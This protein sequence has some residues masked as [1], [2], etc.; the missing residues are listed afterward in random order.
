[1]VGYPT[2]GGIWGY[3]LCERCNNFTGREY[4]SEHEKWVRAAGALL[5]ALPE[6]L[7]ATGVQTEG[8]EEALHYLDEQLG[9]ATFDV[10]LREVDGARFVRQVLS[11]MCSIAGPWM[12]TTQH[13]EVRRIVLE[14]ERLALP[15]PLALVMNLQVGSVRVIGPTLEIQNDG[16]WR[17]VCEVAYP[18]FALLMVLARSP[19]DTPVAGTSLAQL[20]EIPFGSGGL[21]AGYQIGFAHTAYPGDWR[22]RAQ[23]EADAAFSP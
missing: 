6:R 18:P 7:S 22:T 12:L 13:P 15:R 14:K 2:Q 17:W 4:G 11:M 1:M 16:Q 5:R 3:T 23:V 21:Q 8:P 19:T 9:W 20:T 10:Q